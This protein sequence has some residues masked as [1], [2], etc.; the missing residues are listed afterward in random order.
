MFKY[1][2]HLFLFGCLT[3]NGEPLNRK[4]SVSLKPYS[5]CCDIPELG[6]AKAFEECSKLNLRGPC[7]DVQCIFEKLGFLKDNETLNKEA[8]IKHLE[9]WAVLH[10]G[11]NVPI[12]KVI[13][14][15]VEKD[16][17]Q[18]L[19][20][21]CKAYDVFA[22]TG[23]A[24][25]K[26]ILGQQQ[27]QYP[28]AIPE[29]CRLPP[30]SAGRA[31]ECCTLPPLIPEYDYQQ[32]NFKKID[33]PKGPPGP[34]DCEKH[35]CIL[36]RNNLTRTNGQIDPIRINEFFNRWAAT[37]ND[38]FNIRHVLNIAKDKCVTDNV[39]RPSPSIACP[40]ARFLMCSSSVILLKCPQS[41]WSPSDNC[42][43]LRDY[44]DQCS[45]IMIKYF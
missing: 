30:P 33:P 40:P 37:T 8:Y 18:Y 31:I 44:F 39:L 13:E 26:I 15:C 42:R 29:I 38:P 34:L 23:I 27:P 4:N 25:L 3:I 1:L 45:D 7:D 14:E 6:E 24:M 32:C 36:Q 21:S 17:R 35:M 16:V 10:E 2:I 22:C 43:Q 41:A 19:N 11:W 20:V 28:S 5:I 12:E 9:K